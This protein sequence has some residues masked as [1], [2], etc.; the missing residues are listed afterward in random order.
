MQLRKFGVCSSG[1]SAG[2]PP[3]RPPGRPSGASVS[4]VAVV[5]GPAQFQLRTPGDIWHDLKLLEHETPGL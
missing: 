1:N 4:D 2:V 5:P 3:A